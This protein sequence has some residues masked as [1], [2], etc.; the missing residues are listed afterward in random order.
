MLDPAQLL[1]LSTPEMTVLV[2]G[3][4]NPETWGAQ[5]RFLHQSARYEYNLDSHQQQRKLRGL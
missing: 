2:G 4:L 1:S 5:H 3:C